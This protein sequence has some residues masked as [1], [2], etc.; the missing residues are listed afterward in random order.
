MK[1]TVQ[2]KIL[3]HGQRENIHHC[4]SSNIRVLCNKSE[5]H[6][7]YKLH[8]RS[9]SGISFLQ[10]AAAHTHIYT[11]VTMSTVTQVW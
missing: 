8:S 3:V 9:L 4:D 5:F 7:R 6:I 10:A 11:A 1:A 2:T